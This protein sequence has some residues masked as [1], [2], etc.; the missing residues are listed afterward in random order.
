MR[1]TRSLHPN[2]EWRYVKSANTNVAATI[3]RVIKELAE[4]KPVV[5]QLKK[6]SK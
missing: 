3:R 1:P 5:V 2:P 6:V 4:K